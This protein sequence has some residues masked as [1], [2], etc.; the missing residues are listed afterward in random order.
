MG[1]G[2]RTCLGA[3]RALATAAI[4]CQPAVGR[5]CDIEIEVRFTNLNNATEAMDVHAIVRDDD[6]VHRLSDLPIRLTRQSGL[7]RGDVFPKDQSFT[8]EDIELVDDGAIYLA[9]ISTRAGGARLQAN[10]LHRIDMDQLECFGVDVPLRVRMEASGTL[11]LNHVSEL[12][13]ERTLLADVDNLG[14]RLQL[15]SEVLATEPGFDPDTFPRIRNILRESDIL[16]DLGSQNDREQLLKT[17]Y[18]LVWRPYPGEPR[19]SLTLRDGYRELLTRLL[20]SD[21]R[22][23]I[24]RSDLTVEDYALEELSRLV[25]SYEDGGVLRSA[26]ILRDL[27]G[28]LDLRQTPDPGQRSEIARSCLSFSRVALRLMRE[29]TLP[30]RQEADAVVRALAHTV[31]CTQHYFDLFH[32]GNPVDLAGGVGW[33][34]ADQGLGQNFRY[35]FRLTMSCMRPGIINALREPEVS[36][37]AYY[38]DHV[39][40][41]VGP[42]TG[43]KFASLNGR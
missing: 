2:V 11:T 18:D 15:L 42:C 16:F 30:T 40:E 22:R 25:R 37:V 32:Q 14:W 12:Q 43:R 26:A 6:G 8:L 7:L 13:K 35:D 5:A 41:D 28:Q 39:E 1:F 3:I 23:L 29:T 31:D 27:A 38:L 33:L 10:G 24:V 21:H 9:F 36:R 20:G 19:L 4:L 17:L 34:N